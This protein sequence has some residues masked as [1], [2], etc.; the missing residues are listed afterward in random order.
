MAEAVNAPSVFATE[1]IVSRTWRLIGPQAL[2]IAPYLRLL[3]DG[4]VEGAWPGEIQRW[5]RRGATLV[6]LDGKGVPSTAF[7]DG[8]HDRQGQARLAGQSLTDGQVRLLQEIE[9]VAGLAA[10]MP[11]LE[12]VRRPPGARRNLVI[13]RA[14]EQSLHT[15]WSQ[16]ISSENR[17]W[18]MC[19]SYYGREETFPPLDYAEMALLQN[20]DRKF[21][22]I[23]K[24][25][26]ADSP[27]WDYDYFMLPDDDLLWSWEDVNV[28][29]EVARR[30]DLQI[31]QPSLRGVINY[32]ETRQNRNFLLRY[33][34]L[35]EI[36]APLFSRA[37]L[38]TCIPT[39]DFNEHGFGIDY[40]WAHMIGA[41]TGSLAIV[42]KVFAI[43]TRET[44]ENYDL[45]RAR[46]EGL[47]V[48]RRFG[49]G[50]YYL[51]Q[52]LG[53]VYVEPIRRWPDWR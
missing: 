9:P 13:L 34:T 46:A 30:F 5:E 33:V 24:L 49:K 36:M 42:D 14:N 21:V 3:P 52:E 45:D 16:N 10:S 19:V 31:C 53:G 35:V 11:E 23:K 1:Q 18:D 28:M 38:Q 27:L 50:D 47:D 51:I 44:G 29:F 17:N 37:A 6:L 8:S 25:L 43:H 41:R 12:R 4:F 22:A 40:A 48:C 26:H 2:L 7:D 15:S 20:Q 39:F 32:N